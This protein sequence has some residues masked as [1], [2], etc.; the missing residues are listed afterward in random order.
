MEGLHKI[1]L[2]RMTHIENIP[3]ILQYGIT[4]IS[5]PNANKNYVPIG[6]SS[7]INSRDSKP[8]F[9][10]VLGDF[11]P[12]YFGFRMPMLYVISRG[13]NGVEIT[14]QEDI[15]Y[16]MSRVGYI[17]KHNLDFYFTDGHAID[18]FTE[19][20]TRDKVQEIDKIIDFKSIRA[21]YWKDDSIPDL[22]RKKQ[23]EFLILGDIPI[24]AVE[25]FVV[26]NQAAKDKLL[27]FGVNLRIEVY[28]N[29]YF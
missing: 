21:K 3:H 14:S 24:E 7:I 25:G 20:Y 1:F 23:A 9:D 19:F 22:K 15:V 16:C 4:H 27:S 18:N 6:D 11:I 28:P 17:I 8:I 5:S 26:F 2:T 12:F 29:F 10:K 13:L